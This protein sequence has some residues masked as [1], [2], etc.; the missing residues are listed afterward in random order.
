MPI[1]NKK[2][3]SSEL[4]KIDKII[5]RLLQTQ[6]PLLELSSYNE[7]ANYENR[8]PKE[9]KDQ[10]LELYNAISH[11]DDNSIDSNIEPLVLGLKKAERSYFIAVVEV[12]AQKRHT[13]AIVKL[14]QIFFYEKEYQKIL[15]S[16]LHKLG[17]NQQ[18]NV[19]KHKKE[20]STISKP[21]PE[22]LRQMPDEEGNAFLIILLPS[23][24][25][26]SFYGI[27]LNELIGIS[28]T[29]YDID[30]PRSSFRAIKNFQD[31]NNERP[32]F[33]IAISHALYLIHEAF[34]RCR[35][36]SL[37]ISFGLIQL[38]QK[39]EDMTKLKPKK[40][41]ITTAS[42]QKPLLSLTVG[43]CWGWMSKTGII[44]WS[45]SFEL[46]EKYAKK[47]QE[48]VESRVVYSRSVLSESVLEI[49]QLATNSFFAPHNKRYLFARRLE[50]ASILLESKKELDFAEK[51]YS[52]SLAFSDLT[53]PIEKNSFAYDLMLSHLIW[54]LMEHGSPDFNEEFA[55]ILNLPILEDNARSDYKVDDNDQAFIENSDYFSKNEG[56]F[57]ILDANGMPYKSS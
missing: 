15:G 40:Q 55:Q 44:S 19:F 1:S 57:G 43:S 49:I 42:N 32:F 48:K 26:S 25:G 24:A 12:L 13:L 16:A 36:A 54:Y 38:V 29:I 46:L 47:I 52:A 41:L 14:R 17:E 30:S 53:I 4:R 39:I 56:N 11:L 51:A 8:S 50:E 33:N 37:P 31:K 23:D 22:A 5:V 7:L 20:S 2:K 27:E 28:D 3:S 35:D 34:Q 9:A 6:P 45:T 18:V 10:I 21:Q